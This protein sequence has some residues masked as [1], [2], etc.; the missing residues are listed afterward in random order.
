MHKA[1][2]IFGLLAAAVILGLV[3]WTVVFLPGRLVDP[4]DFDP[5]PVTKISLQAALEKV[6]FFREEGGTLVLIPLDVASL[7]ESRLEDDLG[8]DISAV[9]VTF[10]EEV[11]V[12]V[13]TVRISDIPATGYLAWLLSRRNT[14]T[15]STLI[16]ARPYVAEGGVGLEVREFRVGR[17]RVPDAVIRRLRG[18]K[19][20]ILNEIAVT[21]VEVTGDALRVTR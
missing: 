2:V 7:I 5:L 15:T 21:G 14:E 20:G 1:L 13:T 8:L 4:I 10:V 16:A 9:S 17:L 19:P 12:A 3:T 11:V 18:G 6:E